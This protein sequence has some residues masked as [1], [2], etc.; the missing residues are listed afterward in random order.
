[1]TQSFQNTWSTVFPLRYTLGHTPVSSPMNHSSALCYPHMSITTLLQN[2]LPMPFVVPS[3]ILH[4]NHRFKLTHTTNDSTQETPRNASSHP[5]LIPPGRCL[6]WLWHTSR[7]IFGCAIQ[8]PPAPRPGLTG[9]NSIAG[10][11]LPFVVHWP[12]A[13]ISP[14]ASVPHGLAFTRHCVERRILF[15]H[16]SALW[17][18]MGCHVHATHHLRCHQTRR[19]RG[20][21]MHSIH[22]RCRIHPVPRWCHTRQTP[23]S[24]IVERA[25]VARKHL[26]RVRSFHL[27]DLTWRRLCK[28]NECLRMARSWATKEYCTKSQLR[29]FL[30]KLFHICQCCP[31]S[32]LFV[33]RLLETFRSATEHGRHPIGPAFRADIHWVS[34]YLPLYNGIQMI[35]RNPTL[36]T[37]ISVDSCLT[38]GGGHFGNRIYNTAYPEFILQ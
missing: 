19:A 1:M 30:G 27:N 8:T 32:R 26:K 24:D 5:R 15:W 18:Q 7:Y 3:P 36:D 31:T 17:H 10:A 25:W 38:G 9:L 22:R 20:H 16:G 29:K 21:P 28:I 4:S 11:G 14:A 12:S 35:P 34:Q 6:C 13:G 23:L 2:P 37:P 33:N